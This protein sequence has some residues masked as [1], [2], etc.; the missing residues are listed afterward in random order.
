MV[1]K[2]TFNEGEKREVTAT[3]TS[4][5]IKEAV[6]IAS[7]DFELRRTDNNMIVQEGACE[8]IRN[9]ATSFLDLAKRGSYELKVISRVGREVI[10][11]KVNI[12]VK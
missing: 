7:A 1:T 10:I 5:N 6:V 11:S 4:K 3:V 2:I 12:D 9:E 8:V